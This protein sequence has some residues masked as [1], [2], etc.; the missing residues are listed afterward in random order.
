MSVIFSRVYADQIGQG[1][2]NQTQGNPEELTETPKGKQVAKKRGRP[3]R[4]DNKEWQ[5]EEIFMLINIWS[6]KEDLFNCRDG[7]CNLHNAGCIM[8]V[9]GYVLWPQAVWLY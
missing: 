1:Q 7:W 5:D 2:A 6:T 3:G 4:K 9:A 8:Q